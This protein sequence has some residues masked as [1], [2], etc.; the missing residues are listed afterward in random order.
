[1]DALFSRVLASACRSTCFDGCEIFVAGKR[2][3]DDLLD[4]LGL[5]LLRRRFAPARMPTR[6]TIARA[7][8]RV[9][10]HA[11]ARLARVL[12]DR[13]TAERRRPRP[14]LRP[15]LRRP[16]L[17]RAHGLAAAGLD[18][19]ALVGGLRARARARRRQSR[20]VPARRPRG[21]P[22][23]RRVDHADRGL[24]DPGR[25]VDA[26]RVPARR[27]VGRR[28]T[29]ARVL[30]RGPTDPAVPDGSRARAVSIRLVAQFGRRSRD[31]EDSTVPGEMYPT[32]GAR[33]VP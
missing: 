20:R 30:L 2:R 1:L 18:H 5:V 17:S 11:A 19:L 16:P 10:E 6:G 8:D 13:P 26:A 32:D 9:R 14:T 23:A 4:V 22:G 25:R 31:G 3:C 33:F 28:R 21:R 12:A 27:S 7:A 29:H 15:H 24:A